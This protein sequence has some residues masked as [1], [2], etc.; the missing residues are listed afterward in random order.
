MSPVL[1]QLCQARKDLLDLKAQREPTQLFPVL[2]VLIRPCRDRKVPLVLMVQTARASRV[3]RTIQSPERSRSRVTM[4]LAL[5]L[6]I[7]AGRRVLPVAK[8]PQALRVQQ[9]LTQLCPVLRDRLA[10]MAHPVP[11]AKAGRVAL[12]MPPPV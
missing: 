6:V 7:C 8:G 2:L 12:T 1:I 10:Q 5:R 9:V 11:T 3:A 4:A